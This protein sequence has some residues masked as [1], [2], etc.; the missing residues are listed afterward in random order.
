MWWLEHRP[1]LVRL[2]PLALVLA[3][4]SRQAPTSERSI[5]LPLSTPF[6]LIAET[7]A[8]IWPLAIAARRQ[9][10][11]CVAD[12]SAG[13]FRRAPKRQASGFVS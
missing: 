8:L 9:R 4:A 1:Q 7:A 11:H 2:I 3:V 5:R 6:S 10:F 12:H 13:R